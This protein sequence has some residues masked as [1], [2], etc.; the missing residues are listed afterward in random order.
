MGRVVNCY[1]DILYRC[2][3]NDTQLIARSVVNPGTNQMNNSLIRIEH[4][5]IRET[6]KNFLK[7]EINIHDVRLFT[8]GKY[9]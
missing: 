2:G 6:S 5:N 7:G 9:T 1:E 3:K 4:R 8:A